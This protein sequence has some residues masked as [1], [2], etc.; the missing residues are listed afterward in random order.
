VG[1]KE[2]VVLL[3]QCETKEVVAAVRKSQLIFAGCAD[4][5]LLG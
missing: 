3:M 4:S 5:I 2:E 1:Y